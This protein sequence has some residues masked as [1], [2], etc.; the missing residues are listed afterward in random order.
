MNMKTF[1][2]SSTTKDGHEFAVVGICKKEHVKMCQEPYKALESVEIG[3]NKSEY[4][5]DSMLSNYIKKFSNPYAI[6]VGATIKASE[7]G[8]C[9]GGIIGNPFIET[10]SASGQLEVVGN[11]IYV[12]AIPGRFGAAFQSDYNKAKEV[13]EKLLKINDVQ[14]SEAVYK[15]ADILEPMNTFLLVS[16]GSGEG[17]YGAVYTSG[18]GWYIIN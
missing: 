3:K 7:I 2:Y 10:E 4:F 17:S 6:A 15:A 12:A 8:L 1:L 9:C 13:H 5:I 16:D 14:L 18:Q 11:N